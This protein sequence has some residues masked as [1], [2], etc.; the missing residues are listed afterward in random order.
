VA[1]T[2]RRNN[3][4]P[5][6]QDSQ[7]TIDTIASSSITGRAKHIAVPILF[8]QEK[9]HHDVVTFKTTSTDLQPADPGTK[10]L[11]APIHF[12]HNDFV[13]GVRFYPPPDSEH[14]RQADIG[15]FTTTTNLYLPIAK[16]SPLPPA[17]PPASPSDTPPSILTKQEASLP[18]KSGTST[19]SWEP[20]HHVFRV[21][22][23]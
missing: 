17:K 21:D 19:T 11:A 23:L 16:R 13:I 20:V 5:I 8:S 12:R 3:P 18:A 15:R 14:Y 22:L 9:A 4:I 6:Y 1:L 10:P 7:P 2:S